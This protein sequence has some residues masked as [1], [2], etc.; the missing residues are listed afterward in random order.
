MPCGQLG[1][2]HWAR[3]KSRGPPE[4]L[5]RQ[6]LW[7]DHCHSGCRVST[8]G[9]DCRETALPSPAINLL[10]IPKSWSQGPTFGPGTPPILGTADRGDPAADSTAWAGEVPS[11]ALNFSAGCQARWV[12]PQGEPA[13]ATGEDSEA[14]HCHAHQLWTSRPTPWPPLREGGHLLPLCEH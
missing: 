8:G 4:L 13:V 7:P 3:G 10:S 5:S 2:S 9:R 6:K 11:G 1:H 12:S 14:S